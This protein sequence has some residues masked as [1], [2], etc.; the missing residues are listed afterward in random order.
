MER[1]RTLVAGLQSGPWGHN[2]TLSPLKSPPLRPT[3][4][5]TC[6]APHNP[7]TAPLG[8]MTGVALPQQHLVQ[9]EVCFTT[10]YSPTTNITKAAP[11]PAPSMSNCG[12]KERADGG[13]D[14][15]G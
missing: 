10:T 2:L 11:P 8:D 5:S 15:G 3:C 4:S 9:R 12:H 14:G 13:E 1:W 7:T 6:P